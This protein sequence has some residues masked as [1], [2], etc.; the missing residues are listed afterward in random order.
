MASVLQI[1]PGRWFGW[2]MIPGC[3]G[4]RNVPYFSP[5]LVQRVTPRKTGKKILTGS[6]INV[7]SAEGVQNFELDLRILKHEADYLIAELLYGDEVPPDRSA[8]ISHIE[9]EWIRRFC[10]DLWF[11][12][13][14]TSVG[15]SAETSVSEYLSAVFG[16]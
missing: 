13:P 7:F 14:P 2:Q 8:V 4:N 1:E 5:V 12:R 9:F 15:G 3:S 10:P 16:V 11:S 6:F